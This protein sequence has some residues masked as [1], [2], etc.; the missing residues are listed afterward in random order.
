MSAYAE[1]G[2]LPPA[3][4]TPSP[5]ASP[6][7]G[8]RACCRAGYRLRCHP[9]PSPAGFTGTAWAGRALIPDHNDLGLL[10]RQRAACHLL[11]GFRHAAE[12]FHGVEA[13]L[14]ERVAHRLGER[15]RL[16]GRHRLLLTV[17]RPGN[18]SHS[19]ARAGENA[20]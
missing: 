4:G 10:G 12:L 11:A 9:G 5:A 13:G 17:A 16:P 8:Y 20:G 19:R 18:R 14:A 6:L 2:P 7:A 15:A 1:A 3:D